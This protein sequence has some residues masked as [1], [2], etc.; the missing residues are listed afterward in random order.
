[1]PSPLEAAAMASDTK[2][3]MGSVVSPMPRL[4]IFESGRF[5]TCARRRFAICGTIASQGLHLQRTDAG[6]Q[7]DLQS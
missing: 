7:Q 4:M 2:L 5:A 1:M 3:G 6:A